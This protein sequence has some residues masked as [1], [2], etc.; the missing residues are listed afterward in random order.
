MPQTHT[1]RGRKPPSQRRRTFLE[2][3]AKE[4]VS[5]DSFCIGRVF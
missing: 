1:V 5:I 2:N 3:R 4:I